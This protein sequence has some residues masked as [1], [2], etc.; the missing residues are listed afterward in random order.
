VFLVMTFLLNCSVSVLTG[1]SFGTAATMGVICATMGAAM[2]VSPLLTGGAVL[3][4]V[5]FGDRCSP[6]STSALLTAELTGS[7]IF[8]NIHRMIGTSIVPFFCSCAVY[9][10]LGLRTAAGGAAP[11][12]RAIFAREF[13]LHWAALAPAA[14]IMILSAFRVSVKKAM[15][16]SIAASVPL[17]LT[18]QDVSAAALVK[19]VWSGFHA[20]D[21]EVG[22]MM[23]GGGIASMLKVG[24]IVCLSSSYSGIFPKTGLLDGA[25]RAVS[26]LA[27]KTSPYAAALLTSAVT[28]V[29]ACNQS[30]CILLTHQLCDGL[31]DAS[32]LALDIEDT[33]VLVAALVPW[34]IAGSV[35]LAAAGAPL[36]SIFAACY[37]YLLP[38][39]RLIRPL[40]R[41]AAH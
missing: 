23:N 30:L 5:F 24:G 12:L 26:S 33:A 10:A 27:G 9:A 8:D 39:W 25:K 21:A 17:C 14:V 31:E 7:N 2:G 22:A 36:T 13:T 35:P 1:T 34:S 18:M 19:M 32:D 11:D 20:A 4:G 29:I 6:V 15:A 38:L 40:P 28:G 3:S 41:K 37:L 16:A